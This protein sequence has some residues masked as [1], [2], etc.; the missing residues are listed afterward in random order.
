MW[1]NL[2]LKPQTQAM[3]KM[4]QKH[5]YG[6]GVKTVNSLN[7]TDVV[8][9]TS[10]LC[11][12]VLEVGALSRVVGINRRVIAHELS[13][14]LWLGRTAVVN[15]PLSRKLSRDHTHC[16]HVHAEWSEQSRPICERRYRQR[17]P[18]YSGWRVARRSDSDKMTV[19][20][21]GRTEVRRVRWPQYAMS[22]SSNGT[23]ISLTRTKVVWRRQ[24]NH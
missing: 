5:Q 19:T 24:W 3:E 12:T 11:K 4:E 16:D 2:G 23:S 7:E 18:L 14:R 6:W 8:R 21:N 17:S 1:K 10:R 20:L 9:L 13:D 22:V 15:L